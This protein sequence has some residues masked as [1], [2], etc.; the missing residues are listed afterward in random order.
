MLADN[1]ICNIQLSVNVYY[2]E[3]YR[4]ISFWSLHDQEVKHNPWF[5]GNLMNAQN[6]RWHS[7]LQCSLKYILYQEQGTV[8][9]NLSG[10]LVWW[11]EGESDLLCSFIDYCQYCMY[12][13]DY[14]SP[15]FIL[16]WCHQVDLIVIF[17]NLALSIS[18]LVH[19]SPP[20]APLSFL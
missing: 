16:L 8:C 2:S 18:Y 11:Q 5:F 13:T 14:D 10:L 15:L 1:C 6:K 3:E 19:V 7:S 20:M 17:C 12:W 9:L 4:V